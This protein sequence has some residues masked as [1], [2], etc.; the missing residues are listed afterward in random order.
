[1]RVVDHTGP[2]PTQLADDRLLN[3]H[4][5]AQQT[6]EQREHAEADAIQIHP[7]G[8]P[9]IPSP[10]PTTKRPD[11]ARRLIRGQ[12]VRIGRLCVTTKCV[13]LNPE[14]QAEHDGALVCPYS[15]RRGRLHEVQ[16]RE[17]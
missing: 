6:T 3:R 5:V 17:R 12:S 1:M 14:R 8:S 9:P 4:F 10:S 15:D 11:P 2:N 16:V 7:R 13:A